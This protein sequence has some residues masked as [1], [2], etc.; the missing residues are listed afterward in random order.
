MRTLRQFQGHIQA[1][2]LRHAPS[3]AISLILGAYLSLQLVAPGMM[4]G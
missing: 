4:I 3:M 1:V 2:S